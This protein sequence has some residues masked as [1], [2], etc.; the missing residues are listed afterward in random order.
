MVRGVTIT[1]GDRPVWPG[2][3]KLDLARYYDAAGAWLLPHVKNRPLTLVRCP[4]GTDAK[5]FYQRHLL[6]AAS[7]G[8]VET[9]KRE[10]GSRA[11]YMY[12]TT[13][14]QVISTVQ[15]GAVEFHTSGCTIPDILHPDRFTLDLDPGPDVPWEKLL[16]ATQLTKTLLDTLGLKSF[17]KTTGGV[18]LHVVV[19]IEPDLDWS[20]VKDFTH[21][22][23]LTLTKARPELFLANMAKGRRGGKVFVDYMRNAAEIRVAVAAY[24]AR[25]RPGATVSTPLSWDELD[26][27]DIRDKFT[28]KSVPR[29]LAKLRADPWR[30]YWTTEQSITAK[31]RAALAAA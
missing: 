13:M 18:G 14:K 3:T 1:H 24:S 20:E 12:V 2:M 30:D 28:I 5:C 10:R 19:P 7:P 9:Y 6:M 17:V 4:D 25:T 23:A 27:T 31:M 21:H 15:N 8:D 22:I 16:E 26:H 11:P 29:R